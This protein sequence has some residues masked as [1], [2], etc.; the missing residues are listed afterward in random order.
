MPQYIFSPL[1][2]GPVLT[3]PIDQ[4]QGG[5]DAKEAEMA[6]KKYNKGHWSNKFAMNPKGIDRTNVCEP[7][8]AAQGL[9]AGTAARMCAWECPTPMPNPFSALVK[10]LSLN[11]AA[12]G[13]KS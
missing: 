13:L 2:C 10:L 5:K 4:R 7:T 3:E 1:G 9:P 8:N 6:G 12:K 11:W